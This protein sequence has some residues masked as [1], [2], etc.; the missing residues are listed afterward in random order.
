MAVRVEIKLILFDLG[1]VLLQ[2]N[3]PIKTFALDYDDAEFH[4]RWL[5]SPAVRAHESGKITAEQFARNITREINLPYDAKTFLE[6]FIGWPGLPYPEVLDLVERI[7]ESFACPILSNT[8]ALH[9]HSLDINDVFGNRFERCFLSFETGLLKPDAQ[10]FT[11]VTSTC[12]CEPD[13]V[14]FFDDNLLNI[15]AAAQA[16]MQAVLCR[17][18]DDLAQALNARN[19]LT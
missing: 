17:T 2:L 4:R 13:Q 11:Q 10:A 8:N 15:D 5:L 16:G 9:W 19:L 18:S 3:D 7:D 14:L 6:K 12:K 1:G